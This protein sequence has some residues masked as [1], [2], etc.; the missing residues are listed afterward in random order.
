MNIQ[1]IN[2]KIQ[3][4]KDIL[5]QHS[6]YKKVQTIEDLHQFLENHVYAVWDFMSLLKA[7]Q[8]NLTCTTTPWFATT[9]PEIRYLINE[10]V[11]AE[12]TDLTLDGRRQS[13]YEMYVEAM[14]DCGANTGNITHFLL[15]VHSLQN[16]FIAIKKS[17]LH[18]NIK[19]FLDFTFRV[20][21]E[22]K[23]HNI[24]AAFTFGREDLIPSM[25]TEILKNFQINFPET[26]LSKL[27]YYFERHIELDADEHGPMAMQMITE[28]CG[29]DAKKW[30]EIEAVSIEALQKRIGLWDAIEE[31]IDKSRMVIT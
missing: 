13:H 21:N 1:T 24:A 3:P 2:N 6:L 19:D 22:G 28:L 14:Q 18:P 23:P 5:L 10:I 25:F 31:Q 20:I 4:Q 16:V 15:E 9:N 11:L 30:K 26:D 17:N 12:E 8:A 29:T 27:I 7:L